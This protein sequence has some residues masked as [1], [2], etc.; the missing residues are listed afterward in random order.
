MWHHL[1]AERPRRLPC[2]GT[3]TGPCHQARRLPRPSSNCRELPSESRC[4]LAGLRWTLHS[5]PTANRAPDACMLERDENNPC[6]RN[7]LCQ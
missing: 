2:V 1:P 7:A 5:E 4:T 3:T 6:R